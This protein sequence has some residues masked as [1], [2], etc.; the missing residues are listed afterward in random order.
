MLSDGEIGPADIRVG[1][2]DVGFDIGGDEFGEVLILIWA[3]K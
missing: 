2:G 1:D 3:G